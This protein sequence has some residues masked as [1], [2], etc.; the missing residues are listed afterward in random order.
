MNHD[1]QSRQIADCRPQ[2]HPS[3]GHCAPRTVD[4][5]HIHTLLA[6]TCDA[7]TRPNSGA[8]TTSIVLPQSRH[9]HRQDGVTGSAFG[10]V[11]PEYPPHK[12]PAWQRACPRA[13]RLGKWHQSHPFNVLPWSKVGPA[14]AARWPLLEVGLVT[15]KESG[16]TSP[17]SATFCSCP[18]P[19]PVAWK[20]PPRQV[21][22]Q[23][24]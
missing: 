17:K 23:G 19:W 6:C 24:Q 8:N 11:V 7:T 15:G 2:R 22:R 9:P 18:P 12:E 5:T 1:I 4:H 21:A 14:R 20:L 13:S 10:P 16:R 3:T